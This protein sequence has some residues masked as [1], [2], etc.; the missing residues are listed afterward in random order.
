MRQI[1]EDEVFKLWLEAMELD[2]PALN[3][4]P[5]GSQPHEAHIALGQQN[6]WMLYRQNFRLGAAPFVTEQ[7]IGTQ[8]DQTYA[9]P[10]PEEPVNT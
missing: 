10:V 6:G 4:W 3:E 5:E 2:N 9:E 1:F 8:N 7:S